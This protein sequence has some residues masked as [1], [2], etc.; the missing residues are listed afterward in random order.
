VLA[1]DEVRKIGRGINEGFIAYFHGYGLILR[2]FWD[3]MS[4][5]LNLIL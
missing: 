5:D 4:F 1:M 2:V 3:I